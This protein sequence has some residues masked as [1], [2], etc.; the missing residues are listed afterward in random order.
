MH[1]CTARRRARKTRA[2]P[3][4]GV[5]HHFVR[6]DLRVV[7]IHRSTVVRPAKADKDVFSP[8]MPRYVGSLDVPR[9]AQV[10]EDVLVLLVP[11]SCHR[12]RTRIGKPV[13]PSVL[14]PDLHGI[15]PEIPEAGEVELVADVILERIQH[16]Y[17]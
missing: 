12:H 4:G 15:D 3:M 10:I 7:D 13:E 8:P 11:A 16:R 14:L 2:I 6:T 17:L 9:K 5:A 1:G